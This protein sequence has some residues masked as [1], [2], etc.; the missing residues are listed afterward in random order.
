V[1]D[2]CCS[3]G[4]CVVSSETI[5]DP[6]ELTLSMVIERDGEPVYT[7][8]TSTSE[9]ER[10]C[11]EL[12]EYYTRHNDVPEVSILLTG[13]SLVPPE[14]FTLREDDHVT[15]EIESIGKLSNSVVT[16]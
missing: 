1:S 9:M 12:V 3:I 8:E 14:S 4:P 16:V 6:H 2:R 10:T 15:I 7:G 5:G 13:T 11:E